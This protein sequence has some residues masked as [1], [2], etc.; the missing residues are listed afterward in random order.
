MPTA[1]NHDQQKTETPRAKLRPRKLSD[2]LLAIHHIGPRNGL[3]DKRNGSLDGRVYTPIHWYRARRRHRTADGAARRCDPN[4]GR[5]ACFDIGQDGRQ[6]CGGNRRLPTSSIWR[7]SGANR[8]GRGDE[9]LG[10]G[11]AGAMTVPMSRPSS[12]APP[13]CAGKGALAF[14]A[15][16]RARPGA[17]KRSRRLSALAAAHQIGIVQKHRDRGRGRR[18]RRR[19]CPRRDRPPPGER[20][21]RWRD[22]ACLYRGAAGQSG[23]PA[24]GRWCPCRWR[25]GHRPR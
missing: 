4:R 23:G 3:L 10:A 17:P 1:P 14:P 18:R 16:R 9:Q 7:R 12:T 11:A 8:G 22:T 25:R 20:R 2:L 19:R 13:G 15:A 24:P 5:R 6:R 21:G